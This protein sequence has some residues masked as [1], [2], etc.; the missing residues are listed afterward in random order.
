[1]KTLY[2]GESFYLYWV[3]HSVFCQSYN[4]QTDRYCGLS[5]PSVVPTL[6]TLRVKVWSK[7]M[8][9]Q[10]CHPCCCHRHPSLTGLLVDLTCVLLSTWNWS[11]FCHV[12]FL[13][14]V[15]SE[16]SSVVSDLLP[17]TESHLCP[18]LSSE[19]SWNPNVHYCVHRSPPLV[20][21]LNE[22]SPINTSPSYF[23]MICFNITFPSMSSCS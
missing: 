10:N 3:P 4:K 9:C 5:H 2:G 14:S 23:F 21:T 18:M 6:K 17:S 15:S 7:S 12:M 22:M 1:M 20:P 13:S 16:F 19:I 11:L 8:H